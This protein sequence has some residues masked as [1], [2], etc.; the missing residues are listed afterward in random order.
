L[1]GQ[2]RTLQKFGWLANAAVWINI[3]CMI[4]T[5]VG[6]AQEGPNTAATALSAGAG[7]S[8][9]LITPVNGVFPP[10][11]HS[12]GLPPSPSFAGSVNGAM[13]AVFSYGGAMIFPEFL[14]EMKRPRDFLKG[15]WAAQIFIYVV[16]SKS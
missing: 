13:Q 3:T 8:A 10:V 14:S 12:N 16:Y 4:I 15:M 2:I 1:L 11:Q 6:A 5:M 7:I 9:T